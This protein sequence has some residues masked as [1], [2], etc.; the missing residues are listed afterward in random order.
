M[1]QPVRLDAPHDEEELGSPLREV[2]YRLLGSLAESDVAVRAARE[3]LDGPAADLPLPSISAIG[4]I[5]LHALR[6]REA[7]PWRVPDF[8]VRD[9]ASSVRGG[10]PPLGG[11]V[12]IAPY[13]ALEDLTPEQ[14]V[15][16]VL[17]DDYAVPVDEISPIVGCSAA[18]TERLVDT[19]RARRSACPTPDTDLAGQHKVV[20]AYVRAAKRGD[21]EA[22]VSLLHEDVRLRSDAGGHVFSQTLD[23]DVA[24]VA[25]RGV[26]L[27]RIRSRVV[28][29][30]VNG[31]AGVLFVDQGD[32]LSVVAWTVVDGR[33][34][35][36]DNLLDPRRIAALALPAF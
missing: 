6:S 11:S 14:R 3:R 21:V 5:C 2:A 15:A 27:C 7:Y 23:A 10:P 9:A 31:A 25:R 26:M 13:V 20:G 30:L 28:P 32:V 8:V 33:I 24:S 17:R 16:V 35:E 12:G 22:V 34:A 4:A 18:E 19:G 1:A 36:I 29:V